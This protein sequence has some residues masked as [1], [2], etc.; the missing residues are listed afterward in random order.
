[1]TTNLHNCKASRKKSNRIKKWIRLK[2]RGNEKDK[3]SMKE[4]QRVKQDKST[5]LI[6]KI[7]NKVK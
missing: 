3:K 1:M 4:G 5:N 2:R 6:S 7:R